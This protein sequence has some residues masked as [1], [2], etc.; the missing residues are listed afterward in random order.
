MVEHRIKRLPVVDDAG[1]LVGMLSRVD[2]LRTMGEDYHLPVEPEAHISGGPARVVGDIMRRK[3]PSVTADA[4]L[5]EVL[6]AVTSTRLNRAIVIDG[7]QQV[8]GIITDQD[9]LARLDPG[10]E[11]GLMAA[12][13]RRGRLSTEAKILA[14]DVMRGPVVAVPTTAPLS[15]AVQRMLEARHKVLPIVD[16]DGRLLG[17]VDRADLLGALPSGTSP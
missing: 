14:S 12:L 2:I 9:L 4:P 10:A 7:D 13:M 5:G 15:E 8:L 3:V 6:D 17:V 16:V 1:Q 11:T